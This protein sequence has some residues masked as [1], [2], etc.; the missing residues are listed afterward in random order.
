MYQLSQEGLARA[1]SQVVSVGER[2]TV[3]PL[4]GQAYHLSVRSHAALKKLMGDPPP[5]QA[6]KVDSWDMI[7]L[8]HVVLL[9]FYSVLQRWL[10]ECVKNKTFFHSLI[11]IS[12]TLEEQD[13]L[14]SAD[15]IIK[16]KLHKRLSFGKK[17]KS[18]L[19]PP[20]SKN[21]KEAFLSAGL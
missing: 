14:G 6:H 11:P 4:F 20:T 3:K 16:E 12:H 18:P 19:P 8:L 2:G 10:Q 17:K 21:P 9:T 5:K 1:Q 7:L 15:K 13:E